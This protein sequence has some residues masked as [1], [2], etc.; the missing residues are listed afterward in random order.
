MREYYHN[1]SKLDIRFYIESESKNKYDTTYFGHIQ[2]HKYRTWAFFTQSQLDHIN[3]QF[4]LISKE[5]KKALHNT[6]SGNHFTKAKAK[7][8]K[9]YFN[10]MVF[11]IYY[12]ANFR[13]KL[14]NKTEYYTYDKFIQRYH[15]NSVKN[16][17]HDKVVMYKK[18]PYNLLKYFSDRNHI[19]FKEKTFY[20]FNNIEEFYFGDLSRFLRNN[21][22]EDIDFLNYLPKHKDNSFKKDFIKFIDY[23]KL[24]IKNN[25]ELTFNLDLLKSVI[26]LSKVF[27]DYEFNSF[28][29]YKK[30]LMKLFKDKA[31]FKNELRYCLN[32]EEL[33]HFFI[34]FNAFTN[35]KVNPVTIFCKWKFYSNYHEKISKVIT[36]L[37]NKGVEFTQYKNPFYNFRFLSSRY[38][39][40]EK[41]NFKLPYKDSTRYNGEELENNY[42]TDIIIDHDIKLKLIDDYKTLVSCGAK[43]HNC[44]GSEETI[45]YYKKTITLGLYINNELKYLISMKGFDIR[46]FKGFRNS[47]PPVDLFKKVVNKLKSDGYIIDNYK[48][49]YKEVCVQSYDGRHLY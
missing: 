23:N 38:S 48:I 47:S 22:I 37:L 17:I 45:K 28:K 33:K 25:K 26:F 16:Y 7:E 2:I 29:E 42:S 43:L 15:D 6:S 5:T 41:G 49:P 35:N 8:S 9:F 21:N 14:K 27:K 40:E 44:A 46:Q 13:K 20:H 19:V 30:C 36:K 10:T 24:F 31:C 4:N 11:F 3:K 1:H 32:D 34:I 39:F 12:G 18:L